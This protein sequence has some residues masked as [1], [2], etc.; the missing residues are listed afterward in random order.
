MSPRP[1]TALAL[2]GVVLS[3]LGLVAINPTS[4]ASAISY[5]GTFGAAMTLTAYLYSRAIG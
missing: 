1:E 2:G 3:V 5:V 4:C